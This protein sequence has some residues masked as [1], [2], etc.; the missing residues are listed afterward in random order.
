MRGHW[1]ND[2]PFI[3]YFDIKKHIFTLV[4]QITKESCIN[5]KEV[6]INHGNK[7]RLQMLLL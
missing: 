4:L 1:A 3:I 5:T 2:G 7:Y 6:Y